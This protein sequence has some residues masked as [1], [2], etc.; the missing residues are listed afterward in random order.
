MSEHITAPFTPEQ[1]AA[2]NRYQGAGRMHPFTCP[3]S[4]VIRAQVDLM[5]VPG[6]GWVCSWPECDYTQDWA[7]DWMTDPEMGTPLTFKESE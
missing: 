5:A 1:A 7:W 4:H 2:L 6:S 3:L